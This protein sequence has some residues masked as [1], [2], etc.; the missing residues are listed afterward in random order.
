VGRPRDAEQ[1]IE[2]VQVRLT[3]REQRIMEAVAHL[4]GTTVAAWARSIVVEAVERAADDPHVLADLEN[5]QAYRSARDGS[6]V[7]LRRSKRSP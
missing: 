3:V 1:K 4:E 5:R 2:Q 6:V 7:P